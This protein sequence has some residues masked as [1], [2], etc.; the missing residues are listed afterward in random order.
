V[1]GV[2]RDVP[3]VT[4]DGVCAEKRLAEPYLIKVDMQ[5]HKLQVLAGGERTLRETEAVILE[6]SSLW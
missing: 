3:V 2:P 6:V 5:A 1:D 4:I